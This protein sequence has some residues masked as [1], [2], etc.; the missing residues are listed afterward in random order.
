MSHQSGSIYKHSGT[1]F[2]KYRTFE[3]DSSTGKRVHKTVTLCALNGARHHPECT[4][5]GDHRT[6]KAILPLRDALMKPVNDG[7]IKPAEKKQI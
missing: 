4:S 6:K 2:L 3:G 7:A 1:W 5:H